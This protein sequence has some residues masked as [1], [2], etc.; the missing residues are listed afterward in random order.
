MLGARLL[1][2]LAVLPSAAHALLLCPIRLR[3]PATPHQASAGHRQLLTVPPRLRPCTAC[4]DDEPGTPAGRELRARDLSREL[5]KYDT[6]QLRIMQ[7]GPVRFV[8][9]ALHDASAA[10][11]SLATFGGTTLRVVPVHQAL[12]ALTVGAFGA[13]QLT[14]QAA[15]LAG[16]RINRAITH[17]GQWYR[18]A[19]PIFLHGSVMH[20][21]SNAISLARIGPLVEGAYG[22]RRVLL[23]YLLS[24]ISG[25]LA[26]LWFGSGRAMSVGASGAVLGLLGAAAAF[27]LRNKRALGRSADALLAQVGQLL[28]LNLVIGLQPRSGIDNLG[29]AGGA[30]AGAVLGLL[31]APSVRPP[32]DGSSDGSV[33]PAPVVTAALAAT[34]ALVGV[35]L[36]DAARMA[37]HLRLVGLR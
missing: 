36:R 4:A 7:S 18:L 22:G 1:C 2:C 23:I 11:R 34:L 27:A 12:L 32:T 28:L 19:S 37:R 6:R 3:L 13:Q 24:G 17:G 8:S 35:A 31:L 15:M 16:A 26:G 20:L 5:K 10:L 30:A 21:A 25:N 14:G 9:G 29:H 33:V